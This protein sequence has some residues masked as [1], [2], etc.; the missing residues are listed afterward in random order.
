MKR[1]EKVSDPYMFF[2]AA[3]FDTFSTASASELTAIAKH[4]PVA[5]L[6]K[7]SFLSTRQHLRPFFSP[8][9]S[10]SLDTFAFSYSGV[11]YD[12]SGPDHVRGLRASLRIL[13]WGPIRRSVLDL[14][15]DEVHRRPRVD[16]RVVGT[17]LNL[18]L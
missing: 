7:T 15:V 8:R 3:S 12:G 5:N 11:P 13:T 16:H 10:T 6:F 9:T 4:S 17:L 14:Q 1:K 2:A 18:P